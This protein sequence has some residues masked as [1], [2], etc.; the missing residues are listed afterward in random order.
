MF[1]R[2]KIYFGPKINFLQL[3]PTE[4]P[5]TTLSELAIFSDRKMREHTFH[6]QGKKTNTGESQ[7]EKRNVP[8]L[9]GFSDQFA[10][11]SESAIQGFLSF[12]DQFDIDSIY[13]QNPPTCVLE[14]FIKRGSEVDIAHCSYRRVDAETLRR[15]NDSYSDRIVG[16]ERALYHILRS[17]YP[18]CREDNTRPVV[19]LFYGPTG[20]G[21]SET[22]RFLAD[23]IKEKLFRR[24]FSMF[25]GGE[26]AAYL[27][28]GRHT[29]PSFARDLM[30]RES[31]IIL[32]DEFDKTSPIFYSAFYQ[33]FDEGIFVD[34]NYCV[35]MKN[36]VIICTS[37]FISEEEARGVLGAPLFARFSAT[38]SFD[39]LAPEAMITIMEREYF[40]YLKN[41]NKDEVSILS[42]MGAIDLL[43]RSARDFDNCRQIRHSVR[44]VISEIL[45]QSLLRE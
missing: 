43:K 41:L 16:Q 25:H 14:Q 13:L 3:L 19:L 28:G 18:L 37:N 35:D 7:P 26:F 39:T 33:L 2:V 24:Q 29:Q 42:N 30:E 17:L 36:T 5:I 22:A 8:C 32:L 10:S 1:N 31:N 38:I 44:N 6:I 34:K 9:V 4:V 27:F 12:I 40:S 45:L 11:I 20:V 21:K 23:V 15:I